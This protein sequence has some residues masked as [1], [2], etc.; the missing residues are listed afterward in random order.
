[1]H[2][3][4]EI[5]NIDYVDTVF[6][7]FGVFHVGCNGVDLRDGDILKISVGC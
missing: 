7:E 3:P 5:Q 4:L 6:V 2:S 1:M